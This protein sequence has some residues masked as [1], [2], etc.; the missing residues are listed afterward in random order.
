MRSAGARKALRATKCTTNGDEQER[1]GNVFELAPQI[2]TLCSGAM[3]PFD[4]GLSPRQHKE[5]YLA[6]QLF[7]HL[8]AAVLN[9]D[10]DECP[11]ALSDEQKLKALLWV[12]RLEP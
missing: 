2:I 10:E 3:Q 5:L 8:Y 12:L 7:A 9:S 11:P 1:R 6:G 4:F